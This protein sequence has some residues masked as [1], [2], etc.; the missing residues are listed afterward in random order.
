MR[1]YNAVDTLSNYMKNL[2]NK[3]K[4]TIEKLAKG[5]NRQ[6]KTPELP[7]HIQ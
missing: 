6:F 3:G 1:E 2:K 7:V 5:L 4:K